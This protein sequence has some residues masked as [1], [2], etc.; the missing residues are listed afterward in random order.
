MRK[1]IFRGM[2]TDGKGFIY[3]DLI[4]DKLAHSQH[5]LPFDTET[6]TEFEAVTPESVG[7]F[8]GLQDKNGKEVFE[9]DLVDVIDRPDYLNKSYVVEWGFS[10]FRLMGTQNIH[11][12]AIPNIH[13]I[14]IIGNIH[15]NETTK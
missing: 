8:T 15:Q 3:G 6:F 4:Q 14:E 7:Q 5:I 11:N 2:R 13:H 1:I 9:G 10:G 12:Q